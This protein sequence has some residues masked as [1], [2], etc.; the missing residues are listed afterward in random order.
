VA[1]D[2]TKLAQNDIGGYEP[3][4]KHTFYEKMQIRLVT[5]CEEYKNGKRSLENFLSAVSHTIRYH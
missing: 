1:S 3:K 4:K 5:L 2:E